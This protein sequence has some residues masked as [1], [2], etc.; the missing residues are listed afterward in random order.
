MINC[1]HG[2]IFKRRKR[3]VAALTNN[4]T[5]IKALAK[6]LN[7]SN[8]IVKKDVD[9]LITQ[10]KVEWVTKEGCNIRLLQVVKCS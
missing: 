1:T 9:E 8:S 2:K 6:N 3:I 7:L 10:R 4:P 5:P